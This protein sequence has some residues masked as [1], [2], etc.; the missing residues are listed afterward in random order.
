MVHT[1]GM[2]VPLKW[3]GSHLWSKRE[4]ITSISAR[5]R[6]MFLFSCACAYVH[7]ASVILISQ[8]WTRLKLNTTTYTTMLNRPDIILCCIHS[9]ARLVLESDNFGR[10]KIRGESTNRYLCLSRKGELVA[11]VRIWF[12]LK[13]QV[14]FC[15]CVQT[16]LRAKIKPYKNVSHRNV[17]F[18]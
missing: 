15:P 10:I 17:R 2:S 5:K 12:S 1:R 3:A 6:N 9:V 7:F 14:C 13:G 8:V 11:R 16:Y 4:I 18:I